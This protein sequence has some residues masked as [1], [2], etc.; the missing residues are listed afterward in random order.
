MASVHF[1]ILILVL[2]FSFDG[3]ATEKKEIKQTSALIVG[4]DQALQDLDNAKVF[5]G[6]TCASYI[7]QKTDF[8][9]RQPADHFLPKTPEEIS[10]FKENGE[11]IIENIFL[12][13]VKLRERL[14]EFDSKGELFS[15]CILKI[16]EGMQYARFTEEYF[17]DWL[18]QN[19]VSKFEDAPILA[20]KPPFVLKNPEFSEV[21]L[22][23]GDVMLIRGVSYVSAMIARIGDEEGNFSHMAI[24][25]EDEKGALYVV[26]S[27][28]QYG[29][30]ITPLGK[31]RKAK[32]PR[33]ALFRHKDSE[34]A[35]KAARIAY[36]WSKTPAKYDFE[37]DDS[38]YD[39]VFCAEV[40]RYA[41]DKASKGQLMVPKFRSHVT[42]FKGGPYPK[43]LGVTKDTLFAPYDIEV[44]PRFEFVAEGKYYPGLR[45]VRMQDSVLQSVYGWMIEKDYTFHST[46]LVSVESYIGKG[47]RQLGFM[48]DEFP[49]YMPVQT[50][51]SVLQFQT[52]AEALEKNLYA[53]EDSYYKAHGYLPSFQEMMVANDTFRKQ[54]CL[55]YK[56]GQASAFHNIF[57]DGNCD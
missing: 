33:V 6:Q 40:V 25:A 30:I 8:L 51:Q 17:L 9:F 41:Y 14:Q 49:T 54:D 38:N 10:Y 16:R 5:N 44:E 19:K 34:L 46:A 32:D 56:K 1:K 7:N 57:R 13:R 35:H 26:E 28:I 4:V 55:Y 31:W 12:V 42:K 2:L 52:V 48:K 29:V 39:S 21:K 22:Q 37:M 15:D 36:D 27:L 20:G 24:V 11:K 45:K 18:V 43:S 50:M 53:K 3:R 23:A 47:I